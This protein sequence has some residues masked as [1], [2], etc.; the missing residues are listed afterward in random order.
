MVISGSSESSV[1]P[2]TSSSSP[3]TQEGRKVHATTFMPEVGTVLAPS[4]PSRVKTEVS[5]SGGQK[6]KSEDRHKE[7]H[8]EP[9]KRFTHSPHVSQLHQ[10]PQLECQ[11]DQ[12]PQL[13]H[14]LDQVK[15]SPDQAINLTLSDRESKLNHV[16]LDDR[17]NVRQA[18]HARVLSDHSRLPDHDLR[19]EHER[20]RDPSL[21]DRID[22]DRILDHDS[23]KPD[24]RPQ[25]WWEGSGR[26]VKLEERPEDQ[27]EDRGDAPF[28]LSLSNGLKQGSKNDSP[29]GEDACSASPSAVQLLFHHLPL[30]VLFFN[31]ILEH[32][33]K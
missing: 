29:P 21:L 26:D 10:M 3:A 24:Y 12:L 9:G 13:D 1:F 11:L 6:H 22:H 32:T 16:R 23:R 20:D 2:Y 5:P 27:L 28:D 15:L 31:P 19:L 33:D 25:S 30:L 18:D 4:K 14:P 7:E 17:L 8:H